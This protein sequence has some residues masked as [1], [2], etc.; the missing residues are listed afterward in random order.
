MCRIV[1]MTVYVASAAGFVEQPA[2]ANG[3]SD[4]LVE[5]F[6]EAGKHARVA[7]SAPDLPLGAPV[8]VELIAEISS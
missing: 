4:L 5:L 2:V 6:G 7:V 8:E 3:A 1:R